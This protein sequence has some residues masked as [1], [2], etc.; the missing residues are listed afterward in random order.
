MRL[1]ARRLSTSENT[2]TYTE[3]DFVILRHD[4]PDHRLVQGEIG[5]VVGVYGYG[6]GYEVELTGAGEARVVVTVTEK[7]IRPAPELNVP[8]LI[9]SKLKWLNQRLAQGQDLAQLRYVRIK[10]DP[11]FRGK[12]AV[13]VI[14]QLPEKPSTEASPFATSARYERMI[15]EHLKQLDVSDVSCLL[16][17]ADEITPFGIEI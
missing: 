7:D 3:H 11:V 13:T 15:S 10:D 2:P 5:S 17:T 16:L 14:I 4:L 8:D 1:R 12:H 6:A 9:L